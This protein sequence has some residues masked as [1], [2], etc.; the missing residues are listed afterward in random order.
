MTQSLN[1]K[2]Q[3]L[4]QFLSCELKFSSIQKRELACA[5]SLLLVTIVVDYLLSKSLTNL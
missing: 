4:N 1:K 3:S 2:V 5:N